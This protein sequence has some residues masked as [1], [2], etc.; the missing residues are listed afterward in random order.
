MNEEMRAE[1]VIGHKRGR[2]FAKG[3]KSREEVFF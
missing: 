3:L 1:E 2:A